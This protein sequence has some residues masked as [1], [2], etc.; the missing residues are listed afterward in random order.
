MHTRYKL[1]SLC[2]GVLPSMIS[3]WCEW[4]AIGEDLAHGGGG[5]A[6]WVGGEHREWK[7]A[8]IVKRIGAFIGGGVLRLGL[9]LSP[10]PGLERNMMT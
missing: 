6:R 1:L 10:N 5:C 9:G 4:G 2:K 7:E 8:L 3:K